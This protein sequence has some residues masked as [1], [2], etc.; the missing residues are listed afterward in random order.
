[1]S[2][3]T[4]T[5]LFEAAIAAVVAGIVISIVAVVV[6]LANGAVA[7]GGSQAVTLNGGTVA[8]TI[9]AFVLSSLVIT[10]GTVAAI[11]AWVGALLN[12]SRLED[13]TWFVVLLLLGLLSLGW[14][15]MIAYV[16]AGPDSTRREATASTGVGSAWS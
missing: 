10:A 4:I 7:L 3:T 15:A 16:F 1:M 13:K 2:K 9:G 6:G 11:A 12:T 14:L 5:L 8:W